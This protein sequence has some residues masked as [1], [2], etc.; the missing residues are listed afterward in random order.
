MGC[1]VFF[2]LCANVGVVCTFSLCSRAVRVAQCQQGH[3][4]QLVKQQ[5]SLDQHKL[6]MFFSSLSFQRAFLVLH[7]AEHWQQAPWSDGQMPLSHTAWLQHIGCRRRTE[8]IRQKTQ[9]VMQCQVKQK[10]L[11]ELFVEP[12][13]NLCTSAVPALALWSCCGGFLGQAGVFG[14]RAP[15]ATL[16]CWGARSVLFQS[17]QLGRRRP[18]VYNGITAL[19]SVDSITQGVHLWSHTNADTQTLKN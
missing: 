15:L 17:S 10:T 13:I 14:H 12:C 2:L 1:F 4:Y 3:L 6:S 11:S 8:R 7:H 9:C 18:G 19:R 5:V 16:L